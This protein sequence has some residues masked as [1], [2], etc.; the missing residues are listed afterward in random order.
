MQRRREQKTRARRQL[1]TAVVA[2]GGTQTIE[3][4]RPHSDDTTRSPGRRRPPVSAHL[5]LAPRG[6][7]EGVSWP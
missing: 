6:V 1:S 7:G 5:H 4:D 2:L 3:N